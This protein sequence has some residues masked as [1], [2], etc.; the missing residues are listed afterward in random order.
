MRSCYNPENF[1]PYYPPTKVKA[2]PVAFETVRIP[3]SL[4]DSKT[5]PPT[6]GQYKNKIV[7]YEADETISTREEALKVLQESAIAAQSGSAP[8]PAYEKAK[9]FLKEHPLGSK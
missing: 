8:H 1:K 9:A 6:I 7:K 5:Y 2:V 4:G 3:A